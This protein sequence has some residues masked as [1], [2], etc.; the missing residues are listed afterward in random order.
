MANRTSFPET[1]LQ[2]RRTLGAP[3]EKV[4]QAWTEPE[5]L[6]KWFA[7]GD[8]YSTPVVEVDLRVGGS[9]QVVMKSP[10]GILHRLS[11]VFREVRPP[12]KLVYTWSW[13]GE[14][15]SE[16]LVTVEFLARGDSTEIILTHEPFPTREA[17]REHE[18]GWSG[19]LNR[20]SITLQ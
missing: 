2:I 6:K 17:Q 3:R 11:G 18:T 5:E 19:C 9:Y 16:T 13:E 20:L 7:P 1:P 8:D 4:F 10:Q 12:A 14:N 15:R